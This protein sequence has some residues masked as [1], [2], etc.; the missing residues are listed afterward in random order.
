MGCGFTNQGVEVT[1][2]GNLTA[3]SGSR[4]PAAVL[5]FF[6]I[7]GAV[8]MVLHRWCPSIDMV[9]SVTH[10]VQHRTCTDCHRNDYHFLAT[11]QERLFFL[12]RDAAELLNSL[13][14]G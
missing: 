12:L 5:T 2:G 7:S 4:A 3:V 1:F 9:S 13:D 14:E 11:P 6:G 8:D 10:H